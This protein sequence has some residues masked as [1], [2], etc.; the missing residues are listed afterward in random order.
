VFFQEPTEVLFN[1]TFAKKG[2]KSRLGVVENLYSGTFNDF[3][4]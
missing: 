4:T 2:S 1:R 3:P